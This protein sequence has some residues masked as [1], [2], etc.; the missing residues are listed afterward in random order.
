VKVAEAL[1]AKEVLKAA[2]DRFL[3]LHLAI[4]REEERYIQQ[5]DRLVVNSFY[6]IDHH[7]PAIPSYDEDCYDYTF[8]R[9]WGSTNVDEDYLVEFEPEGDRILVTFTEREPDRNGDRDV[10][11]W[12]CGVSMFETDDPETPRRW[13]EWRVEKIEERAEELKRTEPEREAERKAREETRLR[14]EYERL[15]AIFEPEN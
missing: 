7:D 2:Q 15:K 13:V 10:H 6:R 14:A 8:S 9:S 5:L 3:G 1:A 11:K 12:W 4:V